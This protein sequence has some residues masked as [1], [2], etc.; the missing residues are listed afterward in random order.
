MTIS[1]IAGP[2][3]QAL[4]IVAFLWYIVRIARGGVRV[5]VSTFT[6]LA[7]TSV[8][9]AVALY[10]EHAWYP[11]AFMT[12]TAIVNTTIVGLGLRRKNYQFKP[13]DMLVLGAAVVGL[14]VWILV[15]SAAW[16]VY[17][18]SVAILISYVPLIVKTFRS[19]SSEAKGPWVATLVASLVF[20]LTIT[21]LDPIHWV[22]QVRQ[23]VFAVGMMLALTWPKT[24]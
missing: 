18:L 16:N 1:E 13:V 17:V 23:L 21:S 24:K 6:V 3:S 4:F 12:L 14:A 9:Q 5:S 7:L 11:A 19:P 8:S 15:H 20:L 10:L 22:V 2:L